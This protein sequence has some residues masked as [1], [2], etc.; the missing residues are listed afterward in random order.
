MT[1]LLG[2]CLIVIASTLVGFQLAGNVAQRPRQ[3]R[4]LR[5]ALAYLETEIGYGTRPLVQACRQIA[6]RELGPVSGL[7]AACARN[8]SQMDGASTYECFQR[9]VEQEWKTTA[10][11]KAEKMIMLDLGQTLGISDRED[12]LHHLALAKSNLEVE[13]EKARE[14]QAR[15][16]K[17]YKTMGV[18]SGALIVILMY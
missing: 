9:A 1:K 2:A 3:I 8:L 7:F 12:Q 5:S 14:E 11:T 4:Q 13:E 17:M 6:S 18:L 10:L 15:Y 16:E